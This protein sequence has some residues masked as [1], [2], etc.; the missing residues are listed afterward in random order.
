MR[1]PRGG[2][3]TGCPEPVPAR[4][5]LTV[6]RRKASRRRPRTR[7]GR[8]AAGAPHAGAPPAAGGAA[9]PPGGRDEPAVQLPPAAGPVEE[10]LLP[11]LVEQCRPLVQLGLDGEELTEPPPGP[12]RGRPPAHHRPSRTARP[13]AALPPDSGSA[14]RGSGARGRSD[15]DRVV[16]AS[17]GVAADRIALR[18]RG[19]GVAPDRRRSVGRH[20]AGSVGSGR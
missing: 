2:W 20:P 15:A 18:R 17:S 14:A 4:V 1:R 12:Q 5:T 6:P 7:P 9:A 19:E 13:P 8:R 10:L 16:P 3:P 11:R